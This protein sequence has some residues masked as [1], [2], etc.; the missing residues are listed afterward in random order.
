MRAFYFRGI[1][2]QICELEPTSNFEP[3]PP[4]VE[5]NRD[6]LT[7]YAERHGLNLRSDTEH[8]L[9]DLWTDVS[10]A[11]GPT[12]L[13]TRPS[14][15]TLMKV[16]LKRPDNKNSA[17]PL[18][19]VEAFIQSLQA[20]VTPRHLQQLNEIISTLLEV[21]PDEKGHGRGVQ[22]PAESDEGFG[23]FHELNDD[24]EVR[25]TTVLTCAPS[26]TY[27]SINSFLK[28]QTPPRIFMSCPLDKRAYQ[29]LA[30]IRTTKLMLYSRTWSLPIRSNT[31]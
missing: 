5:G 17:I 10:S 23:S 4:P 20:L 19:D 12:I 31:L 2:I 30:R 16:R 11:L 3:I 9:A 7:S 14:E 21:K 24:D 18:V 26:H 13:L 8:S 1:Q 6:M 29:S 25:V 28:F 22:T 27:L 15:T